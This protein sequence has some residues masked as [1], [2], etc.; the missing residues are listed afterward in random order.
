MS[1]VSYDK[2]NCSINGQICS[3][4]SDFWK[5]QAMSTILVINGINDFFSTSISIPTDKL[6]KLLNLSPVST[7]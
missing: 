1:N 4:L 2:K 3:L 7:K 6:L 5:N